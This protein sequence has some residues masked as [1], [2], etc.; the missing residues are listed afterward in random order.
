M[1]TKYRLSEDDFTALIQAS[2]PAPYM[3]FGGME[4]MSPQARA[5]QVWR[6]VGER[7]GFAWETVEPSG[8]DQYEFTAVAKEVKP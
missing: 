4:P 3:V 5:E 2:Q 1:R 6:D 8:P 7:L